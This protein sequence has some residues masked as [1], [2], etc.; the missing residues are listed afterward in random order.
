MWPACGARTLRA[1][2]GASLAGAQQTLAQLPLLLRGRVPAGDIGQL[3]EGAEPEQ[4]QEPCARSVQDR[5]ELGVAGL[6]DQAA[7]EQ[8]RGSRVGADTADARDL[9]TRYRLQVG[10]DRQRLGLGR[11]ER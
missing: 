1:D 4:L 3:P 7:L 9:R 11:G 6:F 2:A 5:A 10:D 8:R